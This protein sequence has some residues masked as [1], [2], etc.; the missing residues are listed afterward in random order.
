ML[1]NLLDHT[2]P[3]RF[4]GVAWTTARVEEA[5]TPDGAYDVTA[6]VELEADAD[7]AAPAA[8]D[9]TVQTTLETGWLRITWVAADASEAVDPYLERFPVVPLA[10]VADVRLYLKASGAVSTR[11]ADEV[12]DRLLARM[13][14]AASGRLAVEASDRTLAPTPAPGGAP[15]ERRFR[16]LERQRVVQVPDLRDVVSVTM[17]TG[18]VLEATDYA[19]RRAP[20]DSPCALWVIL[21]AAPRWYA[22]GAGDLSIVGRWGP[23]VIADEVR[24]AVIVW[25]AR[26][27][28]NRAARF[29]DNVA[30]PAGGNVLGYFRNLPPD[31]ARVVAG[32]QVPG[33]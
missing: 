21:N 31:V 6:T 5:A 17:P 33:L 29:A 30:D 32:L 28:H 24:E 3:P 10:T 22:Y 23:P 4:D 14:R 11:V 19:L 26:A 18:T 9:F 25:T 12:D 16:L 15:V 2:P 7:A 1:V 27:Y 20:A 13:L 8:R